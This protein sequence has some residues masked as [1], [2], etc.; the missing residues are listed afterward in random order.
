[1][2]GPFRGSLTTIVVYYGALVAR[3]SSKL[4]VSF[5]FKRTKSNDG[6]K[7]K[8]HCGFS[9][10]KQS[11]SLSDSKA[12]HISAHVTGP[13]ASL[14]VLAQNFAGISNVGIPISTHSRDS[15]TPHVRVQN[16]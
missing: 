11:I 5:L 9:R 2:S 10:R 12:T 13:D 16:F 4:F 15:V 14:G 8:G 1:M 6:F 3:Y 7:R